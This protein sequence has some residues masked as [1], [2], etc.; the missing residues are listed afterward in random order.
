[1]HAAAA[2]GVQGRGPLEKTA[3]Q[4]GHLLPATEAGLRLFLRRDP[5]KFHVQRLQP[6]VRRDSSQPSAVCSVFVAVG[7]GGDAVGAPENW[8][9]LPDAG[10]QE[11]LHQLVPLFNSRFT[12]SFR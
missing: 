6:A 10:L 7:P 1:M 5:G 2:L 9:H 4:A 12:Y 3:L 8:L 11:W